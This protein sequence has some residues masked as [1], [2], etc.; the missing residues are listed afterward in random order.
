MRRGDGRARPI[1]RGRP[2]CLSYHSETLYR[3]L[4]L[5]PPTPSTLSSLLKG[6]EG[7]G[8]GG[9][10][11]RRAPLAPSSWPYT[12]FRRRVSKWEEE[13]WGLVP[14]KMSWY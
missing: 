7:R 14:P 10:Y 2:K 11:T 13:P 1:G 5:H 6:G 9:S 8:E 3:K 12:N 4:V